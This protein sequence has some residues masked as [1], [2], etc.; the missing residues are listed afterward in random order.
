MR[1]EIVSFTLVLQNDI[2]RT[3]RTLKL[4]FNAEVDFRRDGSCLT[5]EAASQA[6]CTLHD[7]PARLRYDE[8][9]LKN[10]FL[11]IQN[12]IKECTGIST[13][14]VKESKAAT[15]ATAA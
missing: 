5:D 8:S 4:E 10:L 11:G 6:V 12:T 7:V 13:V 9:A 2:E 15:V 3:K 1:I 14:I